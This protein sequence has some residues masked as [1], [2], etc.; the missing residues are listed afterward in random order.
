LRK[1]GDIG[2]H[3]FRLESELLRR[4]QDLRHAEAL[5]RLAKVV[6]E[7]VGV[8]GDVVEAR[9]HDEADKS[10][11]RLGRRSGRVTCARGL[12]H[13]GQ[14]GV[15][16]GLGPGRACAAGS[17]GCGKSPSA[18]LHHKRTA[19]MN[20]ASICRWVKRLLEI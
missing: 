16:H 13:E 15:S 7:L 12:R 17:A 14:R 1:A 18:V 11:V 20:R 9:Q 6:G 5:A 19:N 4:E 3:L 8:G 10:A 2:G